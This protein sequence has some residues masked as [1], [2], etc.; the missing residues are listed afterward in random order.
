MADEVP[1]GQ[2]ADG[3]KDLGR[4]LDV[5]LAD[6]ADAGLDGLEDLGGRARLGRGDELDP[7]RQL[8]EDGLDVGGDRIRHVSRTILAQEKE[9]GVDQVRSFSSAGSS[10]FAIIGPSRGGQA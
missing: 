4:F 9:N 1:A 5:V 7:G 6:D 2:A 10:Q 3:R 8:G